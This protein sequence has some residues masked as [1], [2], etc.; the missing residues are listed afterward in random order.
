VLGVTFEG[1]ISPATPLDA[2]SNRSN[3]IFGLDVEE[4]ESGYVAAIAHACGIRFVAFRV[5]SDA[6]YEG[7]PFNPQ[8]ARASALFT[9]NFLLNLPALAPA[10]AP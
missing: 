1:M 6:P 7:V 3:R 8:A 2:G 10:S 9:L 5:V 4:M